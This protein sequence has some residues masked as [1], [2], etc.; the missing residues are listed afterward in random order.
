MKITNELLD[1]L[2]AEK[3][4]RV[5]EDF[6]GYEKDFTT[7]NFNAQRRSSQTKD[8]KWL[9]GDAGKDRPYSQVQKIWNSYLG[10]SSLGDDIKAIA[11]QDGKATNLLNSDDF[12]EMVQNPRNPYNRRILDWVN[13]MARYLTKTTRSEDYAKL[14]DSLYPNW[15]KE[16]EDLL[17]IMQDLL[18]ASPGPSDD[19]D[20]G[21]SSPTPEFPLKSD[22]G[23]V[24]GR[25]RTPVTFVKMFQNI[26]KDTTNVQNRFK[27]LRDIALIVAG[28]SNSA[29]A[30]DFP[31][32]ISGI[33][34]YDI[35]RTIVRDYEASSAGF[36][37]ENFLALLTNGTIE[38]GNQ[39]IDDFYIGEDLDTMLQMAYDDKNGTPASAKLLKQGTA[40]F[41]GSDKL[42]QAFF[43]AFPSGNILYVIGIKGQ[44]LEKVTIHT[45]KI[46]QGTKYGLKDGKR[47]YVVPKTPVAT[48]SLS[49]FRKGDDYEG[50]V[51]EVLDQA[52]NNI[53]S[54][55]QLVNSTRASLLKMST[56]KEVSERQ[57]A[58][59]GAMQAYNQLTMILD[60]VEAATQTAS[61]DAA[62]DKEVDLATRRAAITENN[63]KITPE[64]LDKLIKA[65]ILES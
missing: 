12:M 65:V 38:G 43:Q 9:I 61:P 62:L 40:M 1:K 15:K 41:T 46:V 35:L 49:P 51:R 58:A 11:K 13:S 26:L 17:K 55:N 42:M 14:W 59:L 31:Q 24:T 5:D 10:G 18:K 54:V 27:R 23:T 63:E 32:K 8:L 56:S 25:A 2:I 7:T 34:A 39:K 20:L 3:I 16:H 21:G 28:R 29:S 53:G 47:L 6:L 37:F 45:K 19:K 64:L 57:K 60:P 22:Y 36:L 30:L 52:L 50:N 48:I 4:E 44:S 33:Y